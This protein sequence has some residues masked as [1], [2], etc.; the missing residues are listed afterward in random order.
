MNRIM[1]NFS[2]MATIILPLTFVTSIWGMN[3]KVPFSDRDDY[4]GF[5]F[6]MGLMAVFATVAMVVMWWKKML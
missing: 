2:A 5:G 3:V 4:A 1:K 6:L